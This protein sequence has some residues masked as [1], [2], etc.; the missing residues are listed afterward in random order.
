[1][2]S[3][4]ME[5]IAQVLPEGGQWCDVA[6]AQTLAAI[7]V[8]LRPRLVCEVGVWTGGS[9]IP[10]LL[11]LRAVETLEREAH[12]LAARRRAVAIDA[13]SAEASCVGQGDA[14]RQWWGSVD[15]DAALHTFLA[16][17]DAHEVRQLCDVV[18]APSDRATVPDAIDLLHLDGNH[19]EQAV[20]DV[21]RFAT[22]VV[23]GGIL[24]LDD[25]GWTGGHVRR[26]QARAV[27][28]GFVE[29][30]PL[31]TGIVLQRVRS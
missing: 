23:P 9:M 30:Y 10:M 25:L 7:V 8:A 27:E 18:R 29:K 13:W 21:D 3:A 6:K 28:M 14:D 17:L 15:H 5:R 2:I 24:V 4:L 19:G 26:A 16:R 12:G 31:G 22:A 20:G 11:A 1:M